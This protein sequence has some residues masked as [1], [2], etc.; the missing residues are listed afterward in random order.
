MT[1]DELHDMIDWLDTQTNNAAAR[2][3]E[4]LRAIADAKPEAW[5]VECR[6]ADAQRRQDTCAD[7]RKWADYAREQ[8]AR[9]EAC[10]FPGDI[11]ARVVPVYRL[12]LEG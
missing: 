8:G 10:R 9:S 4:F 11:E 6:W 7:W 1:R 12:P 5:R 2:T 3:A